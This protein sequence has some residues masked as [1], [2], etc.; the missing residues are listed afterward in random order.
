MFFEPNVLFLVFA[1]WGLNP[2]NY[3]N[4]RKSDGSFMKC[5]T[6]DENSIKGKYCKAQVHISN[7]INSK[8]V[9]YVFG[10]LFTNKNISMKTGICVPE[11]CSKL[12]LS[13]KGNQFAT[14]GFAL[15]SVDCYQPPTF[16]AFD[17]F[18]M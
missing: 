2:I 3:F 5:T 6:F 13:T 12:D 9:K 7:S 16:D 4:E 14:D 10:E 15:E 17:Y 11:S 18:T 8:V 1:T